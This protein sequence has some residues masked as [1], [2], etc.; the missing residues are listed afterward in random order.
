VAIATTALVTAL[1]YLLPENYAATGVGL[2]FLAAT[3]VVALR[4]NHPLEPAH[5]GLELG[6]LLEPEPLSPSRIAKDTFRAL[7]WA[8]GLALLIFPAF[9]VGYVMW[10]K[11]HRP[12]VPAPLPSL[13]DDVLG[14]LFVIALPEEAFYRGYLQTSF[15]DVWRPRLRV[16]GACV[17]PGIVVTAALFALGHLLTEVNPNRLAVFFP[18]LVFGWLRARTKGVGAAIAFHALCNLFAS[19]LARS[20]GLVR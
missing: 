16:L 20:Y 12:F 15:D 9:W 1:S 17:G 5:F 19:Y 14:Q 6:G 11:P 10:W 13:G 3:Y 7:A 18:A 8:F 4:R 2:G